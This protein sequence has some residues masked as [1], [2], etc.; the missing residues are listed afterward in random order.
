M[1]DLKPKTLRVQSI[2]PTGYC[3]FIRTLP[4]LKRG[5]RN[6]KRLHR[7]ESHPPLARWYCQSTR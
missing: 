2:C 4:G 3:D 6:Q 5:E 7:G 1:T